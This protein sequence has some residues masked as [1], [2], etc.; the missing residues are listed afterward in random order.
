MESSV[1]MNPTP[2][3]TIWKGTPSAAV[4]FWLNLSCLL[5]LPIPWALGR[6]ILR[7]NELIEITNQRLRITRGIFSK[8]TDELELYRVQDITFLQPFV[9][10]LFNMG[11]LLLTTGDVSS[12][13]LRLEGIPAD[14]NLRDRLRDAV[15]AC[16]DRKR[17]RVTEID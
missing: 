14:S 15:E 16:R 12:P 17:A 5:I 11:T 4:D 6:W 2:E 10:R 1:V 9:L 7:R 13:E 3:E 8:R